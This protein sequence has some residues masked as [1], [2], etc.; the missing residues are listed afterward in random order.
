MP[1]PGCCRLS[2]LLPYGVSP[3]ELMLLSWLLTY[4]IKT[5]TDHK[6]TCS[7]RDVWLTPSFVTTQQHTQGGRR[8]TG[9]RR[10]SASAARPAAGASSR[11]FVGAVRGDVLKP[12]PGYR[13][14]LP[15]HFTHTDTYIRTRAHTLTQKN[16]HPRPSFLPTQHTH[17]QPTP[18]VCP[19]LQ[20]EHTSTHSGQEQDDTVALQAEETWSQI[21]GVV[22]TWRANRRYVCG[23]RNGG[24]LL[25][26]PVVPTYCR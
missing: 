9:A 7:F 10:P 22:G 12:P 23:C 17:T 20:P 25:D 24:L 8:C 21:R 5:R 26:S 16:T 2:L 15:I 11:R 13:L 3:V 18:T 4:C 14:F 19:S 1:L 6:V